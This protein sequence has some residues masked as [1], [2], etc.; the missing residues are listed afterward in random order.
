LAAGRGLI[1][2]ARRGDLRAPTPFC[3]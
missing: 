1:W 3:P 2:L